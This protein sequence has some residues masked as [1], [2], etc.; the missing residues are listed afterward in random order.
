MRSFRRIGNHYCALGVFLAYAFTVIHFSEAVSL[1]LNSMPIRPQTNVSRRSP[2]RTLSVEQ[3]ESRVLLCADSQVACDPQLEAIVEESPQQPIIVEFVSAFP[4]KKVEARAVDETNNLPVALPIQIDSVADR[5]IDSSHFDEFKAATTAPSVS[6]ALSEATANDLVVT[7][8]ELVGPTELTAVVLKPRSTGPVY[9]MSAPAAGENVYRF[10]DDQIDLAAE[11]GAS[12]IRFPP[13]HVFDIVPPVSTGPHIKLKGLQDITINLNG[14][15]L[16]LTQVSPGFMIEDSERI[17]VENGTIVGVSQLATIARVVADDSAAGIRFEVLSEFR[18]ALEANSDDTPQLITVGL[19]EEAPAGGYRIKNDGYTELFTNRGKTTN[20]FIYQD[21]S[22]VATSALGTEEFDPGDLVWLLHQNNSGHG[23]VLDNEDGNTDISLVDLSLVNIPGMAIVGE[24]VRGLHMDGVKVRKDN[25]DPLAFFAASSDGIHINANGG[26]IVMENSVI[27]ANGDDKVNIKGNYWKI[28]AIDR[29]TNSITTIPAER[30]TSVNRWGWADQKVVFVERDLSVVGETELLVDSIRNNGK[31]HDLRLKNIPPGVELGTLIG[32]VDNSGARVVIRNNKFYESRAQGVLVQSSHVVLD[33]NTFEGIAGPAVKLNFSLANWYEA[34][35]TRN[36]LISNNRF[37]RSSQS[38]KKSNELIHF[39]QQ[40]GLGNEVD[41]IDNVKIIGNRLL[42]VRPTAPAAST[43][44]FELRE[45]DKPISRLG[46]VFVDST[47]TATITIDLDARKIPA[48]DIF[49][50]DENV[51]NPGIGRTWDTA[52]R[53]INEAILAI[54]ATGTSAA[55]VNVAAGS[56]YTWGDAG[57][58]GF[59]MNIIGAG[60]GHTIVKHASENEYAAQVRSDD[61]YIEGISFIGGKTA[62]DIRNTSNVTIVNSEFARATDGDGLNIVNAS[63]VVIYSS[64]A[65]HNDADGFSYT[66]PKGSPMEVI[67]AFVNGSDNGL[68]GLWNSQ[69]ST[70]HKTVRIVRVGGRFERNPTNIS[71]VSSETS[72]NVDVVTANASANDQGSQYLNFNVSG[73]GTAWIVGGDHSAGSNSP[74]VVNA[75]PGAQI[76]YTS[77]FGTLDPSTHVVTGSAVEDDSTLISTPSP[78]SETGEGG[79]GVN[80]AVR[81]STP[82]PLEP[83]RETRGTDIGSTHFYGLFELGTAKTLPLAM[84]NSSQTPSPIS[85]YPMTHRPS[86]IDRPGMAPNDEPRW[87]NT[88]DHV[89][90]FDSERQAR[91][92]RLTGILE[93]LTLQSSEGLETNLGLDGLASLFNHNTL[94]DA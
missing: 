50:V 76:R 28:S 88:I 4:L 72:W 6:P 82:K 20:N 19:A 75:Q 64:K 14:S 21:G 27:E 22:F 29:A 53:D 92:L 57:Q 7:Y 24:I 47:G 16:R 77:K 46:R 17:S 87:F 35:N 84:N 51:S 61:V 18:T 44:S 3:L 15:T 38:K 25:N 39:N 8:Q 41:L 5:V 68:N 37:E 45:S 73:G 85:F 52:F 70:T 54:R 43:G 94:S 67:E 91:S 83:L 12:E 59:K 74:T 63:T 1:G 13:S 34:I 26:D 10:I 32:N 93:L 42:G 55:T 48:T 56:A 81:K 69:G 9:Q 11:S 36:I 30:A 79:S 86:A 33:Q 49:Y 40:N 89:I 60:I 62:F 31:S 58:L 71:D 2:I 80:A 66:N 78:S 65:H 90:T 23:I